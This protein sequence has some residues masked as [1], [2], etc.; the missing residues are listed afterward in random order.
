MEVAVAILKKQ[1]GSEI[2]SK[3]LMV[4]SVSL[5]LSHSGHSLSPHLSSFFA[6][7]L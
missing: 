1:L 6:L 5:S 7:G 3:G 2:P 4:P